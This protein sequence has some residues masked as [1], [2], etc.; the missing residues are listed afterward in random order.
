MAGRKRGRWKCCCDLEMADAHDDLLS[1]P[2]STLPFHNNGKGVK[3]LS[4]S[5]A[6]SVPPASPQPSSATA[7]GQGSHALPSPYPPA[8][9]SALEQYR[10]KDA[11]K[12]ESSPRS[13]LY[14]LS[15][16]VSS[17]LTVVVRFK[18]IG[19]APIMKVSPLPR[20]HSHPCLRRPRSSHS[21]HHAEQLL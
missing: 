19:N 9:L 7:S 10:K 3:T 13:V 21:M 14:L 11:S 12:G 8:A 16:S 20:L 18:A 2:L 5:S 4:M 17:T 15:D 1:S 6:A